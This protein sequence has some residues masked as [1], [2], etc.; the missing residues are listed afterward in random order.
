MSRVL[1]VDDQPAVRF[2]LRMQ[3]ALELDLS[4]VG[5]ACCGEEALE[6]ATQ[7]Q[8]DLVL[9]DINMPGMGG[10][11]ATER[12]LR[13]APGCR[14]VILTIQDDSDTRER[15]SRAGATAFV[16]KSKVETL[17]A[18]IR[19]A[20]DAGNKLDRHAAKPPVDGC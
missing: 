17:L 4:V 20:A 1:I 8:P 6:L 18:E 9:M 2:G 3:L 11:A 19:R 14:V 13:Q 15:A 7:L 16:A 10:L 5:E 12:L